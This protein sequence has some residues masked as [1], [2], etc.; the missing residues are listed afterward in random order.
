[1]KRKLRQAIETRDGVSIL[2][3]TCRHTTDRTIQQD[4]ATF[5][6]ADSGDGV[7]IEATC[8]NR[9]QCSRCRRLME[10]PTANRSASG[11]STSKSR[12]LPQITRVRSYQRIAEQQGVPF[13]I[14]EAQAVAMMRQACI[15]CGMTPPTTGHG[16]TRLRIWPDGLNPLSAEERLRRG[17]TRG[18][19]FMGP[20]H[21]MVSSQRATF[22][23]YLSLV[24]PSTILDR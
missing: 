8:L 20:F 19:G 10:Q 1:M 15:L 17:L 2:C 4:I 11:S 6:N 7:V 5:F 9:K 13:L 14:N 22:V 23:P 16:L 24:H 12:V 3:F 21:P 18:A